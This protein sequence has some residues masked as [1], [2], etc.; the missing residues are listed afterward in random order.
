[1]LQTHWTLYVQMPYKIPGYW[2][3]L[4]VVKY[5]GKVYTQAGMSVPNCKIAFYFKKRME[6]LIG[7]ASYELVYFVLNLVEALVAEEDGISVLQRTNKPTFSSPG[8]SIEKCCA[9]WKR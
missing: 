4:L 9:S 7:R 8:R 5:P 2:S 3:F 1:M 6:H